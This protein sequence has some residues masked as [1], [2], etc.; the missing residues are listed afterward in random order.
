M[1]FL[2]DLEKK[3]NDSVQDYAGARNFGL[4]WRKHLER[5]PWADSDSLHDPLTYD[6]AIIFPLF[7]IQYDSSYGG[8]EEHGILHHSSWS[9][10]CG[11]K[12]SE[13]G[14]IELFNILEMKYDELLE[15]TK[16]LPPLFHDY[17]YK[18]PEEGFKEEPPIP[19]IVQRLVDRTVAG[20]YWDIYEITSQQWALQLNLKV[21][22]LFT[23]KPL[24]VLFDITAFDNG[25]LAEGF[26]PISSLY[27]L[28]TK[29]EREINCP[30]SL[31]FP[32]NA[33]LDSYCNQLNTLLDKYNSRIDDLFIDRSSPRT[34]LPKPLS[35]SRDSRNRYVRP[36]SMTK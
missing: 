14:I 36:N 18:G 4:L 7:Q 35:H 21:S 17:F 2:Q 26:W 6:G 16:N 28:K 30:V 1:K 10:K 5:V 19:L 23:N 33:A 13:N 15:E 32:P 12:P 29:Q 24:K 22:H 31:E 8:D 20:C 3:L 11:F 27:P 25:A 9:G 34:L